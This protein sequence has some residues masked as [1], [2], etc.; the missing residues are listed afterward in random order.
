MSLDLVR[1]VDDPLTG[2]HVIVRS[3][4]D[5]VHLVMYDT[6][7]EETDKLDLTLNEAEDVVQGLSAIVEAM[8]EVIEFVRL[9][10]EGKAGH[11]GHGFA[12][13]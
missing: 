10:N 1:Q 11:E 9:R 13:H 3:T 8:S 6:Y 12:V 4:E 2:E 5:G 7:G